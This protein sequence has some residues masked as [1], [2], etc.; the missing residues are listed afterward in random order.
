MPRPESLPKALR[1]ERDFRWRGGDVSRIE[2]LSDVVFAFALTLLVVSL[3]V[4][5]RFD[6]LMQ[7]FGQL[8]A[9]AACFALLVYCW[10]AHYLFHR[11]FGF[12]DGWTIFLNTLLLF[13]LLFYVYPLKF[14]FTRLFAMLGFGEVVLEPM[15]ST[16]MATLMIVY[17]SGVV[18]VF[19]LLGLNYRHAWRKRD[20]LE[21]DER[22]RVVTRGAMRAHD[23][24]ALVGLASVGIA[25]VDLA[26]PGSGS[27]VFAGMIYFLMGPLHALHGWRVGNRLRALRLAE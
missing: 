17:S 22:E 25:A 14:L 8:P 23:L 15:S 24:S 9:F 18:V 2:A 10:H 16:D 11:R 7:A 27:S 19:G 20:A 26:V 3:E 1:A 21:L 13:A 6:E 4:P 12:E 5:E